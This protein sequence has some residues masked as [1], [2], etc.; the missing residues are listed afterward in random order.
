MMRARIAAIMM[1]IVLQAL[2]GWTKEALLMAAASSR[3]GVFGCLSEAGSAK[4]CVCCKLAAHLNTDP[5]SWPWV[6][7]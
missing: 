4:M 1:H 3:E 2:E 5:D 6:L 7:V